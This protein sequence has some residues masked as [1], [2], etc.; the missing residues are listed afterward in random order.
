MSSRTFVHPVEALRRPVAATGRLVTGQPLGEH[1]PLRS[2]RERP[3]LGAVLGVG[4][5]PLSKHVEN[6]AATVVDAFGDEGSCEHRDDLEVDHL[7]QRVEVTLPVEPKSSLYQLDRG[8][9]HQATVLR[10]FL[11]AYA[12]GGPAA[13]VGKDER[14]FPASAARLPAQPPAA[15]C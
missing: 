3:R 10:S 4:G 1:S 6:L 8:I 9:A 14:G 13:T 12:S 15:S 2:S 7:G 11:R 5:L